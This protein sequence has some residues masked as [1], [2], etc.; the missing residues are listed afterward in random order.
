LYDDPDQYEQYD[1]NWTD[2]TYGDKA[3]AITGAEVFGEALEA[4]V[5]VFVEVEAAA[6]MSY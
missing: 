6:D 2:Q 1:Q 3:E 5:A 4:T